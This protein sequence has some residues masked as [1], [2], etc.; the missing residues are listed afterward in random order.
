MKKI[1]WL[2]SYPKSG[3]T[4]FR[5]FLSHLIMDHDLHFVNVNNQLYTPISSAREILERYSGFESSLLTH[6]ETDILR[7][8]VYLREAEEYGGKFLFKKCHDAY[9]KASDGQWMFPAEATKCCIYLIRNPFDVAVSLFFHNNTGINDAVAALNN[10]NYAFCAGRQALFNQLRQRMGTWSE[11]VASWENAPD[12]DVHI[13]RYEDMEADPVETFFKTVEFIGM[14]RSKEAV[15][16]ALE[17]SSM[18]K[19]KKYEQEYG[20]RE[21]P[22]NAEN[23]FRKGKAGDWKNHLTEDHIKSIIGKNEDVMRK[24]GYLD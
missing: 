22:A 4:W 17:L 16:K 15:E 7:R 13:M 10:D 20:F 19:L 5:I 2:A 12:M 24:F 11:H 6:D 14:K 9:V 23:F 3:N 18:N 21:K 8:D 1:V